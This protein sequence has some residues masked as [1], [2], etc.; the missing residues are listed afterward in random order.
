MLKHL[1]K[2][3]LLA[4]TCLALAAPANAQI[5]WSGYGE[6][7]G[8]GGTSALSSQIGDCTSNSCYSFAGSHLSH[9]PQVWAGE[10][11]VNSEFATGQSIQLDLEGR[12]LRDASS[13]SY[14]YNSDK[15]T[16]YGMGVHFALTGDQYRVGEFI[17]VG[18]S[19]GQYSK[20]RLVT[21]G[22]EGEWFFD[23]F[24]VLSQITYS[25][26]AQGDFVDSGLN[27]LYLYTGGRYFAFDN[28]MFEADAGAGT[29]EST[30]LRPTGTGVSYNGNAVHW[31]AKAE[32]RFQDFPI[33]LLFN[34]QG[35]YS[36]WQ[37]D[38]ARW[39][40]LPCGS[41]DV[42]VRNTQNWRRSENLVMLS[43]RYYFGQDSL[44]AN[45]R[46]G[47][48]LKDYNPWYGADP[49]TEAFVGNQPYAVLTSAPAGCGPP[50]P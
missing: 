40:R 5:N 3:M 15:V 6:L 20:N 47:A 13:P 29:I 41:S 10:V 38:S 21:G 4:G 49:V 45:D 48:S 7:S 31:S 1:T 17:S 36:T 11:H 24:T 9:T 26:A 23:R 39:M 33:S 35:S 12:N 16:S 50:R 43:L 27:S 8:G 34:Y 14:A 25:R 28:L 44:I 42:Y 32:Y 19:D 30:P 37:S 2:I 22:L 46:K 18:N